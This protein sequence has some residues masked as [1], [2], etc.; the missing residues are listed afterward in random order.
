MNGCK[1]PEEITRILS[2]HSFGVLA[3]SD[4]GYPY[5]SLIT[6]LVPDDS[7]YLYFPTPR[8]TRK[9]SNIAHNANVSVLLDNRS[10]YG[11]SAGG[12]YA[13]SILGS[14]HEVETGAIPNC[15][16]QFARKHPHL[17]DFIAL[18]DTA[19]IQV[20]ILKIILVE[21]FQNVRIF[22]CPVRY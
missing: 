16:D 7:R 9:Y 14:A 12:L 6:I 8:D 5:T 13:L 3:T 11:D 4:D 19:L 17:A 22:D 10:K 2:E 15:K 20:D 21:E 18:P 1:F